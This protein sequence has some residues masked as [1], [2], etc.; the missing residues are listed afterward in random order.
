M[1]AADLHVIQQRN[2]LRCQAGDVIQSWVPWHYKRMI[3]RFGKSIMYEH[4][5]LS[6]TH[7][8]AAFSMPA[9]K[10]NRVSI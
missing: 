8:R 6:H 5:A 1:M 7:L 4:A 9:G 3:M 10:V 2:M